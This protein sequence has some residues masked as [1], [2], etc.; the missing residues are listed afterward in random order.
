VHTY[1]INIICLILTIAEVCAQNM[2]LVMVEVCTM[3]VR[4]FVMVK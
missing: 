2:H 4:L 1:A 3:D